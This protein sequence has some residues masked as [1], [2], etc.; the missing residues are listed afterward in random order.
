MGKAS[1]IAAPEENPKTK[2]HLGTFSAPPPLCLVGPAGLRAC[3][4]SGAPRPCLLIVLPPPPRGLPGQ[5]HSST[6]VV[7]GSQ[8][9]MCRGRPDAP[10]A[11]RRLAPRAG[12]GCARAGGPLLPRQPSTASFAAHGEMEAGRTAGGGVQLKVSLTVS[13]ARLR[14]APCP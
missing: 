7:P 8:G 10:G 9:P 6:A 5:I 1:K 13:R 12:T 14:R 11:S 4:S 3:G 2:Q